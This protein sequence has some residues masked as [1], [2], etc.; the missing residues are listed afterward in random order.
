[1]AL[2]TTSRKPPFKPLPDDNDRDL[3][4]DMDDLR[5]EMDRLKKQLLMKQN[6]PLAPPPNRKRFGIANAGSTLV[7]IALCWVF[8]ANL[9]A[10]VMIEA[11]TYTQRTHEL[12]AFL[13]SESCKMNHEWPRDKCSEA[14]KE[15]QTRAASLLEHLLCNPQSFLVYMANQ[16]VTWTAKQ[17]LD[18]IRN[19]FMQFVMKNINI[20]SWKTWGIAFLVVLMLTALFQAGLLALLAMPWRIIKGIV[21]CVFVFMATLV[22]TLFQGHVKQENVNGILRKGPRG[23]NGRRPKNA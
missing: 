22:K 16:S 19:F 18:H 13:S 8:F 17:L 7:L 15:M 21:V 11:T 12:R 14:Q 1:M 6:N 3:S 23:P 2:K 5:D 4:G 9:Y 10:W 20:F